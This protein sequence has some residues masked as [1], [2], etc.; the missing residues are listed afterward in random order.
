LRR[1][2]RLMIYWISYSIGRKRFKRKHLTLSNIL[3]ILRGNKKGKNN[4]LK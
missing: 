2:E 1:I 3:C 4:E